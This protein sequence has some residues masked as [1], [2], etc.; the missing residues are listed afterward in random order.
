MRWLFKHIMLFTSISVITDTDTA[1]DK[2]REFANR[3]LTKESFC[4]DVLNCA[5]AALC[6]HAYVQFC[7]GC[8]VNAVDANNF[9]CRVNFA[10]ETVECASSNVS[11]L[12]NVFPIPVNK[13]HVS[14]YVYWHWKY[15]N[16][17]S[18]IHFLIFC[19]FYRL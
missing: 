1:D 15:Q 18:L 19:Q 13:F 11:Y 17:R 8:H 14:K 5:A 3:I 9:P 16:Y 10:R 2:I 6:E 7:V 4:Q 12:G